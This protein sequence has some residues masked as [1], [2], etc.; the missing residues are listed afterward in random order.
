M[1]GS[2]RLDARSGT[3]GGFKG[4][5]HEGEAVLMGYDLR[6][7]MEPASVG[8]RATRLGGVRPPPS[9]ASASAS[10]ASPGGWPPGGLG[11]AGMMRVPTGNRRRGRARRA[12]Q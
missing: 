10:A 2:V 4:E 8:Y 1:L 9:P 3:E 5:G 11:P 12:P 6:L 7:R